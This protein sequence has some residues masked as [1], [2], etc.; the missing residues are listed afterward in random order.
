MSIKESR[1]S[2]NP[3]ILIQTKK[4][5]MNKSEQSKLRAI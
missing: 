4:E 1:K 5:R 3:I 2:L